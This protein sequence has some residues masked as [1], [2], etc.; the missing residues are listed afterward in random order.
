MYPREKNDKSGLSGCQLASLQE[1]WKHIRYL[2][3]LHPFPLSNRRNGAPVALDKADTFTGA[4][5]RFTVCLAVPVIILLRSPLSIH[6][7]VGRERPT[8]G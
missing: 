2:L 6:L 1:D 7:A 8:L 3:C 5:S 4:K